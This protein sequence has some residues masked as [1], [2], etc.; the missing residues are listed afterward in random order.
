M[1]TNATTPTTGTHIRIQA[2]SGKAEELAAFLG[3]GAP[4]IKAGEPGTLQWIAQR[5]GPDAFR[6][7]D[8]FANEDGRA[9]HFAGAVAAALQE[10]APGLVQSGWDDGVVANIRNGEVLA[11]LVRASDA[12]ATPALASYIEIKAQ[13]GQADNLAAF[14]A[15]GA[16]II[17]RTEPGTLLWYALRLDATTFAIYDVFVDAQARDAHFAGAVASALAESAATLV[18][19]GWD[20]GVVKNVVHAEVLSITF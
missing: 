19:G 5:E 20:D 16:A 10:Q 18:E 15:G 4:L 12:H 14:L 9:A 8:F 3:G 1:S 2:A 11:S 6:I 13:A 17:E 7:V